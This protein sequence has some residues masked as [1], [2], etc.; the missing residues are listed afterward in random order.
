MANFAA[1]YSIMTQEMVDSFCDNFYIPAEV[2]PTAPERGKTI[3]QF[4]AGKVGVYSRIFDVCGYRIPFTKFFM[5]VLKYFRVHI[6]Q[7]SPFGAARVSHFEVLTRVLNLSPSVTVFRAFYTRSYSDGLFSFV[8]RSTSAPSCFP[9]PPDSIKNWADHFFWVDSCVFPI[10]VPL[11]T[12]GALEKDSAPHLTARQE[13]T[14]KLLESHKAPFRRYPEC[15]LCLVGLSPYYPFD[16]NSY[17]AFEYPDGSEMGLFDFIKTADPRKVQAVEVQKGDDQVVAPTEERQENVA[18]KEAYLVLG[19]LDEGT[20]AVRQSKEE[21]VTEHP[22]KVKKKRLLK[23]S[24]VL[25]AKKLR[26]DHPTLISGTGGK[27]LAGLEQIRQAKVFWILLPKRTSESVI[28]SSIL[29]IPVDTTAGATTSARANP[30]WRS[31]Q[32]GI[33]GLRLLFMSSYLGP[34]RG[35]ALMYTEFNKGAARQIYLGAEVRSRTEHELELKEKI[36]AEYVARG[37]LLEEKDLEILIENSLCLRGVG[38][39]VTVPQKDHDICLF[40]R[41]RWFC[42][43][44]VTMLRWPVRGLGTRLRS[45]GVSSLRAGFQDFKEKMEIQQEEQAQELFNRVAELEAHVM[46]VSSRLEWEFYPAYLTTL[47]GKRW[48]LTHGI[49]LAL[50]KCLEAGYEHGFSGRSLSVV[51]AYNPEVAK[52]SYINAVKALKDIDFDLVDLLKSKKDAG[53][54]EVLDCFL[55]DEPFAGLPKAFYLQP[56][57]NTLKSEH[58]AEMFEYPRALHLWINSTRF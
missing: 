58:A 34:F 46:D 6:S 48:L 2:H 57:C 21:V 9:K 20:V 35:E 11:Y 28:S 25:P 41:V 52:A 24:D 27:T 12:G 7:L 18:P 56:C 14:V 42:V 1:K 40:T 51:D 4:P 37:R 3:T 53:M 5:A 45:L 26:T 33:E 31:S 13:Q 54:E 29:G 43:H 50:L 44:P 38:A 8:K 22:K 23:Q 17:P 47:A 55:L 15:F 10:S 36:K 49:Q 39:N 32:L 19:D 16:E 30:A